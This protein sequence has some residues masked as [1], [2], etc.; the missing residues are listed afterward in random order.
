MDPAIG[1]GEKRAARLALA[2]VL[3]IGLV[4]SVWNALRVPA[5]TG[6]DEPG[7]LAYI[8]TLVR[9]ARLPHP[10]AGWSTFH[11][12]L[13]YATASLLCR[14]ADSAN[15]YALLLSLRSLGVAAAVICA[16]V[17]FQLVR[18]QRG[19]VSTATVAALLTLFLPFRQLAT[20]MIGNEAVAAALVAVALLFLVDLQRE[21]GRLGRALAAG[22]FT[23]LALGTKYSTIALLPACG[24][25]FLR[26]DLGAR[27]RRAAAACGLAIAVLAGPVYARNLALT[28][29]LF[30][31]TRELEPMRSIEHSFVLRPRLASDYLFVP[32]GVIR[33]PSIA[34]ESFDGIPGPLIHIQK[35]G[36]T[37]EVGGRVL[38]RHM[39]S[40]AGLAY[41]GIWWDPFEVRV[42][43]Q[44][45]SAGS[46]LGTL[47]TLLGVAPSVMVVVGFF[48]ATRRLLST[49]LRAPETPVTLFAGCTLA[50]F[51]VFT[52]QAPSLVAAKA[53]Y[54]L[55]VGV[56]A[57]LFFA[58]GIASLGH[59]ART[60]ALAASLVAGLACAVTF[61]DGVLFS[62]R[63]PDP[64]V[65]GLWMR[66]SAFLPGQHLDEAI[67]TLRSVPV[68]NGAP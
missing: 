29:R 9:E 28:G 7:H 50:L 55:P 63:A 48:V 61:T 14:L 5:L 66:L 24:I 54:L 43:P 26:T 10:L 27:G 58:D 45:H 23:G 15:P 30:P 19:E 25:P 64:L 42:P 52:W 67:M 56:P 20:T 11:P 40:V 39:L 1:G 41:A 44:L 12:P 53:S 6:Y 34:G 60:A 57:A 59:R 62:A 33:N 37:L 21:P 36:Q 31:M 51:V 17:A 65:V 3:L 32:W 18:R 4:Q 13:Y 47:L 38:N 22:V 46:W 2:S 49:R 16:A 68:V 8:F 35:D